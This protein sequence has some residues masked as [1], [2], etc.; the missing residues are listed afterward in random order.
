VSAGWVAGATRARALARRRLGT[1]GV[2]ELA[3]APGLGPAVDV[4]AA[5][6]YGRDVRPGQN[7]AE[8]QH[9]VATVGLWHLRVLAGWL[10]PNRAAPLRVL[11][12]G[13]EIANIDE[14]LSRFRGRDRMPLFRLGGLATAAD[15]IAAADGPAQLREAL[16]RSPWGDPGGES[17]PQLRLA[18]RLS[19]AARTDAG[20]PGA[21]EWAAAFAALT[22][23][24]DTFVAGHSV[25]PTTVRST[26]AMLG[27]QWTDATALPT[28]VERLPSSARWVFDGVGEATE[29]WRAEAHWWT[30]IAEDG[31]RMLHRPVTTPDPVLGCVA[32]LAADAWRVRAALEV[33]ARGGAADATAVEAF[34]VLV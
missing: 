11:A 16:S 10:P 14:Q 2:R 33:A 32:V 6:S 23:A 5:S 12:G 20:V 9:G 28:F 22:I 25:A 3:R 30:R 24:R 13:F 4:L 8:A 17:A 34:D 18:V 15:A 27:S 31:Q 21:R 29:L 7:L 19:W 26:V 1:A